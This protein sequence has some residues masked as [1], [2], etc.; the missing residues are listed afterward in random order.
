MDGG[1]RVRSG[2]GRASMLLLACALTLGACAPV[3]GPADRPLDREPVRV[4]ESLG[5]VRVQPGSFVEVRMVL[6]VEGDPEGLAPILEA[7]FRAAVEDFGAVQQGFRIHLGEIVTT[8]CDRDSGAD[9]GRELVDATDTG[10]VVAL[11]GPQC[12]ATLLGLQGPASAA[13]MTVVTSRPQASTLTLGPDGVIGQER[14]D[15]VWRTSPSSLAEARAA[16]QHAAT[17]LELG[18]A[19]TLHDGSIESIAVAETF[20]LR[21]EALGGTVVLAR[22]LDPALTGE[23]EE[24]AEAALDELLDAMASSEADVALLALDEVELLAV[25]AGLAGRSRLAGIVRMTTSA[26]ATAGVLADDASVGLL[27]AGPVLEFDGVNAVTGMSASQTL[28]RVSADSGVGSPAGWWAYAYDAATLL[29]KSLEDSSL[30]DV[31]GS[32]VLSRAELRATMARAGLG[33]LTGDIRC[34]PEGDCAAR[35]IAIR[36]RGEEDVAT[37]SGLPVVATIID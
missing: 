11:L 32:F 20:R 9:A 2:G 21:F 10:V 37:L 34:S 15:G 30:I 36:E 8:S 3:D 6:D 31:D 33:G 28:E 26:S 29:L 1:S 12:T 16:A 19:V 7:A 25:G 23:D 13:G 4:D 24:S 35:R 22:Q 27:V 17:D 14:A 5:V 18:R